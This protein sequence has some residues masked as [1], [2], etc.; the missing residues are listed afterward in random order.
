MSFCKKIIKVK[1]S[2]AEMSLENIFLSS[3]L[4]SKL[5]RQAN[6]ISNLV[7]GELYKTKEV[8]CCLEYANRERNGP[9]TVAIYSD[10]N[11]NQYSFLKLRNKRE[12]M[13]YLNSAL[14]TQEKKS[15]NAKTEN[16]VL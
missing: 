13:K 14:P 9:R 12:L 6:F 3:E 11:G 8:E 5:R 15:A 7:P 4:Q 2:E 1:A 16:C 10:E